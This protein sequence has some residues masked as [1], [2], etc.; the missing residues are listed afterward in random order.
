MT[1]RS[2]LSAADD[3]G[4]DVMWGNSAEIPTSTPG[5]TRGQV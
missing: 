1:R 2:P 3:D 5:G 4:E